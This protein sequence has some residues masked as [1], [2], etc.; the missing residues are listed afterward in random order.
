MDSNDSFVV[1]YSNYCN[2]SKEFL[3]KLKNLK[4]GLFEKFTKICVDNNTSIPKSITSVPTILVPSHPYPL[5]DDSVRVWLDSMSNQYTTVQ[6][7]QTQ[8]QGQ[9][10]GPIQGPMQGQM[11][12]NNQGLISNS[13]EEVG[14]VAPYIAGEMGSCFSDNFSFLDGDPLGGKPLAHTFTFLGE[15]NETQGLSNL[16]EIDR[17]NVTNNQKEASGFDVA[18]EKYMSNREGDPQISQ[19]PRRA[20]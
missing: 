10:Q 13:Q 8:M 3:I 9:M 14:E 15:N 1:F 6:T 2:H 18:Y 5:T 20:G 17:P 4:N 12:G 16:S 11:Q 19:A 7:P